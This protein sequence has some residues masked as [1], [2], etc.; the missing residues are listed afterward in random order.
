V[1]R[2][3]DRAHATTIEETDMLR[4]CR[5]ALIAALL[6]AAGHASDLGE[7]AEKLTKAQSELKSYTAKFKLSSQIARTSKTEAEGT[8]EWLRAPDGVRF[9]QDIRRKTT[10]DLE[11]EKMVLD[12]SETTM[13][14]G[15]YH[16]QIRHETKNVLK[17][18]FDPESPEV[19]GAEALLSRLNMDYTEIKIMPEEKVAGH[20]CIVVSGS[21]EAEES[22]PDDPIISVAKETIWFAKDTGF[23]VKMLAYDKGG[24]V[25]HS[26]E[27]SD[28]Q[29]DP[30]IDPDRFVFKAAEGI[31][32]MDRS[33]E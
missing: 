10:H 20:D 9:R 32:L 29:K 15:K 31:N 23:P 18:K 25:V 21:R 4:H 11:G 13:S 5:I 28:I 27:F 14:D 19:L 30:K 22:S 7:V 26:K 16:Y 33:G 3:A 24:Q 8:F 6:A 17:Q 2:G 12:E 1:Q